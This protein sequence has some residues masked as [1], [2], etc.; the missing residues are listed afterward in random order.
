MHYFYTLQNGRFFHGDQINKI[1][2]HSGLSW[3]WNWTALGDLCQLE[4]L[5]GNA[6]LHPAIHRVP[7]GS[8]LQF[9]D[10]AISLQSTTYVD[11]IR[12]S[13]PDPDAAVEA[14]NEA[15]ATWAG[16]NPYLSLS[17]GFDS[18]VIL[19]A[20]LS[21]GIKPHLITMGSSEAT[22]VQVARRIATTFGLQHDLISLQPG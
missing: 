5:T 19:S 20:M 16:P 8:I 17:G 2:Q 12:K 11:T 1:L 4:N 15:V 14:L 7:P 22:D 21:Q 6:T 18:R 3:Q 10:G 9:R 13:S